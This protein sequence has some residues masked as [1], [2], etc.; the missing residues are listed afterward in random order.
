M[1]PLL[2]SGCK[3]DAFDIFSCRSKTV[4]LL[5]IEELVRRRRK[6]WDL[7]QSYLPPEKLE[8]FAIQKDAIIDAQAS[9]LHVELL[10]QKWE[11]D[12]PSPSVYID[13]CQSIY[14]C[15]AAF[16]EASEE[17]YRVGFR[18]IDSRDSHGYTPLMLF[19]SPPSTRIV[20]FRKDIEMLIW[21][22]S[23]GANL[24][25][26]LPRSNAV[27]AHRISSVIVEDVFRTIWSDCRFGTKTWP[28]LEALIT[29]H[30]DTVYIVPSVRDYCICACSPGGCTTFSVALR[31]VTRKITYNFHDLAL[32][33]RS[34]LFR[35]VQQLLLQWTESRPGINQAII[36]FLTFEALQLRHTCCTEIDELPDC[37]W[38]DGRDVVEIENIQEEDRQGIHELEQLVTEF[39]IQFNRLGLPIAEFLD[40]HWYTRMVEFLSNR[41]PYDEEY[42]QQTRNLGVFLAAHENDVPDVVNWFGFPTV[43]VD[44]RD[45]DDLEAGS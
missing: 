15:R 25:K 20:S 7:A 17:L 2:K 11:I 5:L 4:R 36:R 16:P 31:K 14:H 23:K 41:G 21:L 19:S 12:P 34:S 10:T 32:G 29:R 30:K 28:V 26:R 37:L 33:E 42:H 43:E 24:T 9:K 44:S 13:G 45:S 8:E 18:D 22:V 38:R 3:F 35:R 1:K 39:D 6:L 40:H 27:V